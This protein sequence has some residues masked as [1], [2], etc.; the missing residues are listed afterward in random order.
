MQRYGIIF[1]LSLFLSDNFT[2]DSKN[3]FL[4]DEMSRA[5]LFFQD[6]IIMFPNTRG[7]LEVSWVFDAVNEKPPYVGTY[8]GVR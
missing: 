5:R 2:F 1:F 7:L 6:T 8:G 4:L 3:G